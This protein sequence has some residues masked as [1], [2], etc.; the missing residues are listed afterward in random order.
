MSPVG[1]LTP[2]FWWGW[3]DRY[4]VI[5]AFTATL[6]FTCP[7]K[8]GGVLCRLCAAFVGPVYDY[9]NVIMLNVTLKTVLKKWAP[10]GRWGLVKNWGVMAI[11]RVRRKFL[12]VPF[13]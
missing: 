10:R 5:F 1:W 6:H 7:Q 9:I 8:G 4:H 13:P 11:R 12:A 2:D 3:E